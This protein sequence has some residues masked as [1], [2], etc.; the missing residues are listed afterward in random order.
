MNL[1][2][3]PVIGAWSS[4]NAD[5]WADSV[6]HLAEGFQHERTSVRPGWP[7][8]GF[9]RWSNGPAWLQWPWRINHMDQ[10]DFDGTTAAMATN[11]VL[12]DDTGIQSPPALRMFVMSALAY[13]LPWQA[14]VVE[15]MVDLRHR[16][17]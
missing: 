7:A 14:H 12:V 8:A 10:L 11:M 2:L 16:A 6:R 15:A 13:L 1:P 5:T 4:A 3:H 17:P 9:T